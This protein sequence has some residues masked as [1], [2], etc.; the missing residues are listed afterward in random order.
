MQGLRPFQKAGGVL[1]GIG[2]PA[3]QRKII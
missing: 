1:P 2:A 3:A